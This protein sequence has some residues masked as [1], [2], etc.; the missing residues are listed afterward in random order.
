[1]RAPDAAPEIAVRPYRTQ[2]ACHRRK[3]GA[4]R[5]KNSYCPSSTSD[6][7]ELR[8]AQAGKPPGVGKKQR[9]VFRPAL[10]KL[11]EAAVHPS[12]HQAATEAEQQTI[13]GPFECARQLNI[14][15]QTVADRSVSDEAYDAARR[16]FS[17]DELIALS[18]A[19]A[20]INAWNRLGAAF[21]FAPPIPKRAAESK[22][23]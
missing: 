17:E 14:F 10:A 18:V 21:R 12:A 3:H 8:Q 9:E 15:Q 16:H 19:I 13:S 11:G 5:S 22:A 1:M 20:N 7:N 23:A 2:P 6:K 4:P